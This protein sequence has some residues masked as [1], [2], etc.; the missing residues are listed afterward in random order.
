MQKYPAKYLSISMP[1]HKNM[2]KKRVKKESEYSFKSSKYVD[3]S[4]KSNYKKE[5]LKI[6]KNGESANNEGSDSAKEQNSGRRPDRR[7]AKKYVRFIAIASVFL[8]I[9]A[10][11]IFLNMKTGGK[12]FSA[13]KQDIEK[14]FAEK[15]FI[16]DTANVFDKSDSSKMQDSNSRIYVQDFII[17]NNADYKIDRDL[18]EGIEVRKEST[19]QNGINK[20]NYYFT[21]IESSKSFGFAWET[22]ID[23]SFK[24]LKS[25]SGSYSLNEKFEVNSTRAALKTRDSPEEYLLTFDDIQKAFGGVKL[26]YD[27]STRILRAQSKNIQLEKGQSLIL[28][29]GFGSNPSSLNSWPMFRRSV[30]HSAHY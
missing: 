1:R 28:D 20:I 24:T 6:S 22:R 19:K 9:I 29:P 25:D 13:E 11:I 23:E 2:S 7:N 30:N 15:P 17:I 10:A 27:P 14:P 5:T 16:N 18:L 21:N 8:L 12:I 26:I 4:N 3:L